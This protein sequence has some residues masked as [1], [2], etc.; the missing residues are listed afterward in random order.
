MGDVSDPCSCYPV[1]HPGQG[2]IRHREISLVVDILQIVAR[3]HEDK[4]LQWRIHVLWI[5]IET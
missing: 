4:L 3:E 5:V 1:P 2:A